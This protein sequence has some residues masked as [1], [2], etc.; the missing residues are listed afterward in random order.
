MKVSRFGGPITTLASAQAQPWGIAV[1]ATSVYWTNDDLREDFN[2]SVMQVPLGGGIFQALASSQVAPEGV[3]VTESAV[4][5]LSG[6]GVFQPA[7]DGGAPRTVAV[8]SGLGPFG[9]YLAAD[10][11]NLYFIAGGNLQRVPLGGGAVTTLT[12]TSGTTHGI[13][14]DAENVYWATVNDAAAGYA[15]GAIMKLPL[16]G[17]TP[18]ALATKQGIP[19][20]VAADGVSVY[21]V[22]PF[23]GVMKVA[24][25]GGAITTLT[26]DVSAPAFIAVDDTSVYWTNYDPSP[27]STGNGGTVMKL[28]PK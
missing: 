5:W 23:Q 7:V 3:V 2:G 10:K 13:A 17:G 11:A 14:V 15:N 19:T 21:W 12:S 20:G 28:T 22:D 8:L 4:Y 1:D 27:L 6:V 9:G 26:S 16:T 25:G 18:V 24:V